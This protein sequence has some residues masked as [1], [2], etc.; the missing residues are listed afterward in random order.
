[1][2]KAIQFCVALFLFSSVQ[3]WSQ[4]KIQILSS[5]VTDIVKGA[6][7]SRTY[8]LRGNVGLR[9]DVAVMYCDSAVLR[10]PENTFDA[11]GAVRIIQADTVKVTGKELHYSGDTK[12]FIMHRNVELRTPSSILKTTS[13]VYDRNNTTAYY[14]TRSSL[15]RKNLILT[16]DVG[17]YNTQAELVKLRGNVEA[18]DSS[19]QLYTDTLLYF[20]KRNT[21]DFA[22]PSK[23]LKDSTTIWCSQGSYEA[24][25]TL[26]KLNGGAIMHA[27]RKKIKAESM[28]YNLRMDRGELFNNAMVSDT[29]QGMVLQSNYI[30]YQKEPLYV[31]AFTPVLY[32][33]RMN[34]D[35][36][37]ALGDTLHI[38][39]T[40]NDDKRVHLFGNTS[41]YS[42]DFQGRSNQFTY[43]SKTEELS[44]YPSPILWSSKSQFAAD[45]GALK[46]TNEDLDSLYLLGNVRILNETKDTNF[47]DQVI[48]KRLE[49]KFFENSLSSIRIEGNTEC[50]LHNTNNADQVEGI[51]QSACSWLK[52]TFNEGSVSK[53]RLSRDVQATYLPLKDAETTKLSGCVPKFKERPLIH[54]FNTEAISGLK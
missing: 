40:E 44:L 2:K 38:R 47:F 37:R 53:V 5:D 8:Y 52:L 35:T 15:H 23:L 39:A 46:L 24:D 17:T 16:S 13:L 43:V 18:I 21:Y 20:P 10:Q 26:L 6:G 33:Q 49:G 22:G 30:Q 54:D 48:G 36:L 45:S 3:G 50:I 29:A 42:D 41:F 32:R 34:N 11:F 51:N 14:K 25:Q 27:P 19:Y 28:L 12:T 4:T 7:T 1:M 31:D 9:Q